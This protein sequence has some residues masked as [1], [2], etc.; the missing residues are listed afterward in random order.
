MITDVLLLGGA[1]LVLVLGFVVSLTMIRRSNRK[2]LEAQTKEQMEM[3]WRT[4][5][6][7]SG[8]PP[9]VVD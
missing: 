4:H 7:C 3:H 2:K 5:S 6:G 1:L 8:G 9:G